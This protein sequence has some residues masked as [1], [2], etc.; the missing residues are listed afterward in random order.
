VNTAVRAT[1]ADLVEIAAGAGS[2]YHMGKAM[3]P[4]YVLDFHSGFIGTG[5]ANFAA[6]G[7][8]VKST[9]MPDHTWNVNNVA[10]IAA[11]A[12]DNYAY[13]GFETGHLYVS[14]AKRR[15][16][17]VRFLNDLAFILALPVALRE[18]AH[19]TGGDC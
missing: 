2:Q 5:I 19:N 4:G 7:D 12:T 16:R 15:L 8:A 11:A 1:V 9:E 13:S 6:I 10:Y 3:L 14:R 17:Y 18:A